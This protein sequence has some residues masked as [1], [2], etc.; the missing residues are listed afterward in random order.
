MIRFL[1]AFVFILPIGVVEANC[2]IAAS[3]KGVEN[4]EDNQSKQQL[5]EAI[6]IS[7]QAK[8]T[9]GLLKSLTAI[10]EI[11][12]KLGQYDSAII[13]CYKRLN[14]NKIQKNYRSLS[15]N[16]RALNTLLITNLDTNAASGLMDSCY[17]YALLSGDSN[18]IIV[19][20]TNYGSYKAGFDKALG[21][22]YL[23]K[24]VA[25]SINCGSVTAYLYLGF[26]LPKF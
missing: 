18:T 19:A 25:E 12:S 13:V 2:N 17:H 8:D 7:E 21:L 1:F 26:R 24:A 22:T 9:F 10:E 23:N 15:D 20:N 5:I 6:Y 3:K 4:R 14:L 11:Y 16:F